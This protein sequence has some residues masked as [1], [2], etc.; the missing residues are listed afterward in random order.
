MTLRILFLV[1]A[2]LLGAGSAHA[3]TRYVCAAGDA[4]CGGTRPIRP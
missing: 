4:T 2:L 1:C 3:A